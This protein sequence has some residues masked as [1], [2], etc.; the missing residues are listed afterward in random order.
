MKTVIH[1]S[2]TAGLIIGILAS[3]PMYLFAQQRLLGDLS[4]TKNSPEGYVTVNG[5][6]VIS[7][8]S[9]SSPSIISTSP[10]A[11]SKVS[12]VKTGTVILS[13]DSK[14]NLSFKDSSISID[15]ISGEINI[16]TVPNT[17][18]NIF[19]PD[20]NVTLPIENQVNNIKV[21]IVNGRTQ[22]ETLTGK[23]NFNNVLIA[24]G[25]T[26]PLPSDT[27]PN[28]PVKDIDSSKGFNPLLI[29]GVLGAVGGIA[30]IALSGS[31]NDRGNP[32]LSPTR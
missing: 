14:I 26:Y 6:Q 2:I 12:I 21:K 10:Q 22:I 16:E 5:V 17:S 4:V 29:I 27:A 32:I 7:G 13:P 24:A 18:L 23:A 28:K 20:G 30:L 1:K 15:L 31:S 25:E 9:I 8:R 19:I 11:S 3:L